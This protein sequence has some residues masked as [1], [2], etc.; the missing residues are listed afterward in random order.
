[1]LYPEEAK[2]YEEACSEHTRAGGNIDFKIR[3]FSNRIGVSEGRIKS[4]FN[5]LEFKKKE[6][7]I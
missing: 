7:E 2:Q 1:M 4:N 3:E 5:A 6:P